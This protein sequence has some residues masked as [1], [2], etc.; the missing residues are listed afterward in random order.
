MSLQKSH[1]N[2]QIFEEASTWFV[3]FR[4]DDP[5]AAAREEFRDWIRR[6][7]E[8]IRAYL[9]IAA[10]YADIPVPGDGRSAQELIDLARSAPDS[11]IIELN[12]QRVGAAGPG[13]SVSRDRRVGMGQRGLLA[14]AVLVISCATGWLL[15]ERDTYSTGIGEQRSVTLSD[16]SIVELNAESKVRVMYRSGHRDV[17]LLS[18]QALF[19]VAKDASRPFVVQAGDTRVRAVGTQFDVYLRSASTVVTVIEGRVA[20]LSE[21]VSSG[22]P[23]GAAPPDAAVVA[24]GEQVTVTTN[25]LRMAEK[26][27]V[28]A[29][30]A[31]TQHQLV[32]DATPLAE[33]LAEFARYTPRRIIVDSPSLAALE[34]SG[35]YTSSSPDSLL[36]FLGLQKGVVITQV[37]GETHIRQE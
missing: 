7:P 8:H 6:S 11:N 10:V 18:G 2:E 22:T 30:I 4:V 14:A 36:R 26:P 1:L 37:N 19:R 28:A 21:V 24:A 3:T 12:R 35:Q 16:G 13:Q 33:V 29:A 20:V 25:R 15:L 32:F 31:W 5:G 17:H 34:I 27:N 9:E 23:E